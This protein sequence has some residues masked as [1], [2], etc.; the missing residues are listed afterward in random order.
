MLPISWTA[1]CPPTTTKPSELYRPKLVI[2]RQFFIAA[3]TVR[4]YF[5]LYPLHISFTNSIG[6]DVLSD[7]FSTDIP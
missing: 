5:Y 2:S 1:F 6:T 7:T 3:V 4:Y